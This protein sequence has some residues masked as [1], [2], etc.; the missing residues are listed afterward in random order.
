MVV[1]SFVGDYYF[2]SNLDGDAHYVYNSVTGEF[3]ED[4]LL[5]ANRYHELAGVTS[6]AAYYR[7][8]EDGHNICKRVSY[9][10]I[11]DMFSEK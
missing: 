10:E 5:S 3:V 6:N 7:V 9:S 4:K 8:I 11:E 2:C 1:K